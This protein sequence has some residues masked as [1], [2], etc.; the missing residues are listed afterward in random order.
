M[1]FEEDDPTISILPLT[2]Y[3]I[4][5][6]Q[7]ISLQISSTDYQPF[8]SSYTD[9]HV[10]DDTLD[11]PWHKRYKTRI[12]REFSIVISLINS[13]YISSYSLMLCIIFFTIVVLRCVLLVMIFTVSLVSSRV[14]S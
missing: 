7:A 13:P 14:Q 8:K 1:A 12:R 3:R 10:E 11:V 6:S 2:I 9:F 5:Y 4:A